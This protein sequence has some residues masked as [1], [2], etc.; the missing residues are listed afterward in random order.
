VPTTPQK[1]KKRGTERREERRGR[2]KE[3]ER[4]GKKRECLNIGASYT[5]IIII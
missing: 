1:K 2:R 4:E 5:I 3:G